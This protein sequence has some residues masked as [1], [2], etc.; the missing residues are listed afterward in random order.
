MSTILS[1]SSACQVGGPDLSAQLGQHNKMEHQQR[2]WTTKKIA[3]KVMY[4]Y[5]IY[6]CAHGTNS[7]TRAH[8]SAHIHA[9]THSYIHTHTYMHAHLHTH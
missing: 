7:N 4:V 5:M 8:T 3:R 2:T 9:S 1:G 6:V